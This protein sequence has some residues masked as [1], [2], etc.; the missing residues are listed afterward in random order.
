VAVLAQH[1]VLSL[2]DAGQRAHQHAALSDQV[3]GD[4][5]L[6]RGREE[7]PRAHRDADRQGAVERHAGRV[8]RHGEAGVDADA[9]EEVAA[10]RG[11]RAFRGH[12][13]HVDVRAGLDARQPVIDEAETVGEVE[14]LA[15]GHE[16]RDARPHLLDRGVVHE[17]HDDRGLLAGLLDIEERLARLEAV[18]HR[19]LPVAGETLVLANDDIDAVVAHVER[20]RRALHAIAND[21]DDLI[22]EDLL[23]LLQG[24]FFACDDGFHNTAKINLRHVSYSSGFEHRP[25]VSGPM[26][27]Q[28]GEK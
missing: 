8:L 2:H 18:F 5:M 11:A 4:L 12:Q 3:G 25:A 16:R 6:E 14:R 10:H 17:H 9:R 24:I 27:A 21:G 1:V 28:Q 22:L 7:V 13:D 23:R 26:T 15:G 19:A 20:L